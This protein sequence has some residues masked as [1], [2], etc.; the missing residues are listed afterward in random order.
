MDHYCHMNKTVPEESCKSPR[1][2]YDDDGSDNILNEIGNLRL[3][4]ERFSK[5][6]GSF[7]PMASDPQPNNP[8]VALRPSR[9]V[10][11][12]QDPFLRS[13]S[14]TSRWYALDLSEDYSRQAVWRT[15][16]LPGTKRNRNS[17]PVRSDTYVD[18]LLLQN[19]NRNRNSTV[20]HG[21][22]TEGFSKSL[23]VPYQTT[24]TPTSQSFSLHHPLPVSPQEEIIIL[25]QQ[26]EMANEKINLIQS[27][28]SAATERQSD[29]GQSKVFRDDG[30]IWNDN[31]SY[32]TYERCDPVNPNNSDKSKAYKPGSYNTSPGIW[33]DT[34]RTQSRHDKWYHSVGSDAALVTKPTKPEG[35]QDSLAWPLAPSNSGMYEPGIHATRGF[36]PKPQSDCDPYEVVFSQ[37]VCLYKISWHCIKVN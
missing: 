21:S 11:I 12:S 2:G 15:T 22:F 29:L 1:L 10:H 20:K 32:E 36:T 23:D 7:P 26:L 9:Q 18:S 17:S 35:F 33:K 27:Q 8:F 30:S 25:K 6:I 14:K 4:T 34:I 24:P 19:N 5:T 31:L 13:P 37:E 28:F 16:P 3:S